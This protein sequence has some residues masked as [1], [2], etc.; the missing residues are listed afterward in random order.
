MNRHPQLEGLKELWNY[1]EEMLNRV[2]WA[3]DNGDGAGEREHTIGYASEYI[4]YME[5]VA[6]VDLPEDAWE[7]WCMRNDIEHE[8]DNNPYLEDDNE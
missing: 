8:I 3:N 4:D 6:E 2:L 1:P 5:A 7:E